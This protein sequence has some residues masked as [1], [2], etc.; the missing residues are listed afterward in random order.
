VVQNGTSLVVS[1]TRR[2]THSYTDTS[3]FFPNTTA[4]TTAD[5]ITA[6]SGNN[7]SGVSRAAS[8]VVNGSVAR[9][10]MIYNGYGFSQSPQEYVF[11]TNGSGLSLTPYGSKIGGIESSV[12][13]SPGVNYGTNS[14]SG[15]NTN[16]A[17]WT[18]A[19]G[20]PNVSV[21]VDRD[22]KHVDEKG[23]LSHR[24]STP[25]KVKVIPLSYKVGTDLAYEKWVD[26]IMKIGAPA[27]M[28]IFPEQYLND[29]ETSTKAI[30]GI[31]THGSG[32]STTTNI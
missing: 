26:V 2:T 20:R 3:V 4:F 14:T 31:I 23:F 29:N 32:G 30:S 8:A 6:V 15:S 9:V 24:T 17:P 19:V 16:L 1:R 11:T 27:G 12:I 22:G 5:T 28:K 25:D 21:I 13:V 7:G 18:T 10:R